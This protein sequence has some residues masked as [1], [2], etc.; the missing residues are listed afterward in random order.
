MG[1]VGQR[2]WE[3]ARDAAAALPEQADGEAEAARVDDLDPATILDWTDDQLARA[4]QSGV[5]RRLPAEF[6]DDLA[7][8]EE[9]DEEEK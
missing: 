4:W 1:S 3:Y 6:W 7:Y 5:V 9:L 2:R 8:E